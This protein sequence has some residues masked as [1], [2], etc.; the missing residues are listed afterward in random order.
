VSHHHFHIQM[1]KRIY[2][3]R[4]ERQETGHQPYT[5]APRGAVFA[6]KNFVCLEDLH[7]NSTF[8][9]EGGMLKNLRGCPNLQLLWVAPAWRGDNHPMA[10]ELALALEEGHGRALRSLNVSRCFRP[11]SGAAARVMV[12][13][14]SR[15]KELII[16]QVRCC[17][18]HVCAAAEHHTYGCEH[19]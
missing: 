9:P 4:K 7:L 13:L 10:P 17:S 5:T 6:A 15:I 11:N 16:N 2:L 14:P 3:P 1:C 18:H 19:P 12:T 8:L